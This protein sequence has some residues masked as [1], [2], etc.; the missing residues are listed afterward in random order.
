METPYSFWFGFNIAVVVLLL[1]DLTVLRQEKRE[2]SMRES[3]L[4][5][6]VWVILAIGFG[7]WLTSQVGKE[8]GSE[9]FTGYV[10]E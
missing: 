7:F 8:K 5:T 1:L 9:F 3:I 6:L 2:P 4:T 10:I